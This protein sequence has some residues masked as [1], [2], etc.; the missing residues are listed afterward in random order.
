[1]KKILFAGAE[2]MPFAATGG[3][4]DVLGS[5]PAALA[6]EPDTDVRVILPLYGQVSDQWRTKMKEEAVFTVN[7][8]WRQ[9]YCG[10]KSLKKDGVTYY[11]IDNEYYFKRDTLYGAFDDGERFAFYCMAV[12]EAMAQLDFYPDVL[13]A[14]D[15]QAALTVVYLAARY[16]QRPGYEGIRS[17]FTIHNIEYQGQ[18]H[19]G[20]LGDVFGLGFEEYERMDFGGCINLMKAAIVSA[21]AVSTV[22]PRY[23]EE[24][25]TPEY[26]KGLDGILRDNRH[27]LCGILNGIDYSYYNPA[28]DTVIPVRY[29]W[30]TREQKPENKLALQSAL[31]LPVGRDVPMLAIISRLVAHKGLDIIA[32]IA[33]NL[34]GNNDVQLVVLGRGD[35][36]YETFFTELEHRFPDKVRAL[37]RYDRDLAKEIYA[38][39]DIFLMPSKTEPCGLS[40]MIASRYGAIPVVRETGGLFDSIKG[41]WE[42]KGRILGNGF[43]FAGYSGNELLNCVLSAVTLW[44]DAERRHKLIG[45]IMRTDFSWQQSARSYCEMYSK[46]NG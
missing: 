32:E 19:F 6:A 41:Y 29:S 13:H 38:A 16:R 46:L 7:L 25:C 33:A 12:M 1:M 18:Y 9:L 35:E 2:A 31:G 15:W 40:Q 44:R 34:V 5:L 14:H 39:A 37:M 45:K 11:F 30:R 4:G 17:V 26:G 21:D 22:S 36:S 20:I 23:A 24:I 3:L 28:K 27:K 8:S 42:D 10:I 43:T